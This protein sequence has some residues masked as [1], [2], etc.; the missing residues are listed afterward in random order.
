MYIYFK[1]GKL[2]DRDWRELRRN[3][4]EFSQLESVKQITLR[5]VDRGIFPEQSGERVLD[6]LSLNESDKAAGNDY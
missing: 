1:D 2:T 5:C 3:K 4:E 6:H